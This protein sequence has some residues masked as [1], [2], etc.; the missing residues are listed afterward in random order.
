MN[1]KHSEQTMKALMEEY[2]G[3][4]PLLH[5]G[6]MNRKSLVLLVFKLV[7]CKSRGEIGQRIWRKMDSNPDRFFKVFLYWWM[8]HVL[9]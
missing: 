8:Q 6:S 7:V 2:D 9:R 4:G 5:S 3:T 1:Y